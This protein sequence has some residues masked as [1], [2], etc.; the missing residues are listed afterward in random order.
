MGFDVALERIALLSGPCA[1]HFV[2]KH[3]LVVA[4]VLKVK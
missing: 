2:G 4:N 3:F 1:E